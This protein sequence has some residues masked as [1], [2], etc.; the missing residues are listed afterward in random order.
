[1]TV[2]SGLPD[3]ILGG[4]SH[5]ERKAAPQRL[6]CR[7][8][9]ELLDVGTRIAVVGARRA[10]TKGLAD[11]ESIV[12]RLV[13]R[14]VVVVSGLALGIDTVAHRT[15]IESGGRTIAVLGTGVD[16][17]ATERNRALQDLVGT[18][19]LLVSQFAPTTPPRPSNFPRRNRVMALLADAIVIVEATEASGTMH[20]GWEAIRLGRPVLFPSSFAN[21][22]P[23]AWVPDMIKYGAT[24]LEE[25]TL[26]RVLGEMPIRSNEPLLLPF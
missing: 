22:S 20:L 23:P 12:R 6:Y 15:A 1:M 19:H 13:E 16:C 17:Y 4:L 11:A 8:R 14:D 18:E 9:R 3:E 5:A 7:G 10:T 25:G 24:V 26:D 2:W 21:A